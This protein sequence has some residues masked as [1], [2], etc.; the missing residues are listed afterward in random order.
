MFV[1]DVKI[2]KDK[3]DLKLFGA[4]NE[5]IRSKII[6]QILLQKVKS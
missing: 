2:K 1:L 4:R 5:M 6:W 3:K